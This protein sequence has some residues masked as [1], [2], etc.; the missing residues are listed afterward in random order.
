MRGKTIAFI[1]VAILAAAIAAIRAE[2]CLCCTECLAAMAC[3][4]MP[5]KALKFKD[6]S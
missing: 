4:S 2:K 6:E 3:T 5:E 1:L